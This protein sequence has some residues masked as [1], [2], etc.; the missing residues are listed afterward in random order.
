ML[1]LGFWWRD[2]NQF[3]SDICGL[4]ALLPQEEVSIEQWESVYL[5]SHCEQ[6][7]DLVACRC[8][9]CLEIRQLLDMALKRLGHLLIW[10]AIDKLAKVEGSASV[11]HCSTGGDVFIW[12]V[13]H[14]FQSPR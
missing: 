5:E 12:L 4:S 9:T 7:K 14:S 3:R 11:N 8:A 10:F 2:E 6:A 13:T 1:A